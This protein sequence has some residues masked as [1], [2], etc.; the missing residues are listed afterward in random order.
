MPS[1]VFL[2][3][4]ES[5]IPTTQMWDELSIEAITSGVNPG[6]VSTMR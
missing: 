4:S 5:S 3:D 6:G 2:S 1:F